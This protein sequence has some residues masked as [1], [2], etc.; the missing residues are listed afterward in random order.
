MNIKAIVFDLDGTI[1]DSTS[2]I[3][4]S[5][6]NALSFYKINPAIE[7][8]EFHILMGKTLNETL[9]ILIPNGDSYI[10]E[11][12]SKKYVDN[13]FS[14]HVDKCKI[15][16]GVYETIQS[17]YK[18]SIKLSVFTAKSTECARKELEAS[19]I[20]KFFEVIQG[21]EDGIPP[22]PH[23]K[24]L[25]NIC[26]KININAENVLMV[27]D[28]DK[29]ILAGKSANCYTCAVTYNHWSKDKFISSGL[30]PDIFIDRFKD[31]LT[32]LQ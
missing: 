11:K 19:N 28:T 23:P 5:L 15:F 17:L 13:Y 32:V 9:K 10:Y 29:D 30:N 4:D 12:V 3:V 18:K 8:E 1:I 31:I 16:P 25:L 6:F 27:G 20:S 2:A 26:E 21:T 24:G 22:K 14:E 7:K